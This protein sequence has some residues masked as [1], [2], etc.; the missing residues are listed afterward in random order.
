MLLSDSSASKHHPLAT[1]VKS[2]LLVSLGLVCYANTFA[3]SAATFL[4]VFH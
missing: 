3:H 2:T 1:M 4:F